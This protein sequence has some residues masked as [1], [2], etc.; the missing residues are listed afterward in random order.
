MIPE[1]MN[2]KFKRENSWYHGLWAKF[3][4]G[5]WP[6]LVLTHLQMC[7][8]SFLE[9]MYSRL[10]LTKNQTVLTFSLDFSPNWTILSH[11]AKVF[12]GL[13]RPVKAKKAK[14]TKNLLNKCSKMD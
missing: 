4:V 11:L 7:I 10:H 14:K 8:F 12:F 13:L 2:F 1:F 6:D 9:E 3:L 5:L